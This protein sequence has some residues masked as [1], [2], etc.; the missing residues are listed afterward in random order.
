MAD[1]KPAWAEGFVLGSCANIF[2]NPAVLSL[3]AFHLGP[4][5]LTSAL[6]LSWIGFGLLAWAACRFLFLARQSG[7]LELLLTT[8]VG[9]QTL[10][11]AHWAAMRQLL[12]GPA[13]LRSGALWSGII[14]SLVSLNATP[15][16]S[17]HL[18]EPSTVALLLWTWFCGWSR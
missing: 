1:P 16:A 6:N 11:S 18:T 13:A 3:T 2:V 8:P 15:A 5:P 14:I 4:L 10:V 12:L 17:D 7:G 9:A